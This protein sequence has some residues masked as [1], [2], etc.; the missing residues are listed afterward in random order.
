MY[1]HEKYIFFFLFVYS[2]IRYLFCCD[3]IDS[4]RVPPERA[5]YNK[6]TT[7]LKN[8]SSGL[9]EPNLPKLLLLGLENN[10]H[11]SNLHYISINR[12]AHG[13]L[14][15]CSLWGNMS[16]V[17][18]V[19]LCIFTSLLSERNFSGLHFYTISQTLITCWAMQLRFCKGRKH[20]K[21]IPSR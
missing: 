9:D 3:I 7:I 19:I 12:K 5:A 17:N 16:M 4:S 2:S 6:L 10:F 13:L 14:K 1:F 11:S 8:L 18:A 15:H 21:T 20:C